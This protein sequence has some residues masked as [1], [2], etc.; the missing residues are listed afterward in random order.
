[1]ILAILL[2][3]P[4]KIRPGDYERIF[5][6]EKHPRLVQALSNVYL[7]IIVLCMD[8]RKLICNQKKS[9]LNRIVK[10]VSL[11]HQFDQVLRR[12]REHKSDVESEVRHCHIVEAAEYREIEKRNRELQERNERGLFLTNPSFFFFSFNNCSFADIP[13][14]AARRITLLAK[15]SKVNYELKHRRLRDTRNIKTGAWLTATSEF[16]SWDNSDSSSIFSCY[17]IRM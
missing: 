3:I 2:K 1:M 8:L 10:P 4:S 11:D 14:V 17:G 6:R 7:D 12:F 5:D 9:V 15:L 13:N 16:K